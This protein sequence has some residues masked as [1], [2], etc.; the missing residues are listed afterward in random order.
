MLPSCFPH[1]QSAMNSLKVSLTRPCLGS[2]G[3]LQVQRL[4]LAPPKLYNGNSSLDQPKIFLGLGLSGLCLIDIKMSFKT[5]ASGLPEATPSPGFFGSKKAIKSAS[6]QKAPPS[7]A[8]HGSRGLGRR[9]LSRDQDSTATQEGG[10]T[11]LPRDPEHSQT[12][13]ARTFGQTQ[14]AGGRVRLVRQPFAIASIAPGEV[15][16][17]C[18]KNQPNVILILS[19]WCLDKGLHHLHQQPQPSISFDV[20]FRPCSCIWILMISIDFQDF[21]IRPYG[22]VLL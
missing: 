6:D 10:S 11:L 22:S 5:L 4:F 12:R 20:D 14:T 19:Q 16:V 8:Q 17:R 3:H 18:R 2:Q 1:A 7:N 13:A 21:P 15:L 9:S